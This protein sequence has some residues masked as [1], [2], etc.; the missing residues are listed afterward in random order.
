MW[1]VLNQYW[2]ALNYFVE[3]K[4]YDNTYDSQC[5]QGSILVAEPF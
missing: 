4:N 5:K 2:T 1:M 3:M